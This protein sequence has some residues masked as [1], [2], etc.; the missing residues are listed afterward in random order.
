MHA[1]L[2]TVFTFCKFQWPKRR[3]MSFTEL[4]ARASRYLSVPLSGCCQAWENLYC[5]VKS[6]LG[7]VLHFTS[8]LNKTLSL[9]SSVY[10][11][12]FEVNQNLFLFFYFFYREKQ[13]RKWPCLLTNT[14][15]FTSAIYQPLIQSTEQVKVT[16]TLVMRE[17]KQESSSK[18]NARW[19][20]FCM[21]SLSSN[22]LYIH[23]STK[24][25]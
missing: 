3:R 18:N 16:E 8:L 15:L 19:T 2:E 1:S 4:V 21:Y 7:H 10:F 20:F 11:P 22:V 9:W 17:K 12:V 25:L 13:W 14:C 5:V 24:P 23:F 6:S